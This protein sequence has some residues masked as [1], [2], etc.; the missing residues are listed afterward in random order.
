MS[1]AQFEL[2]YSGDDMN[3]VL[4]RRVYEKANQAL[5]SANQKEERV[6]LLEAWRDFETQ[7]GDETS[8]A[9]LMEKM[10]KRVKKR[11]RVQGQ[12]GV[13]HIICGSFYPSFKN[14][15][16][17]AIFFRPTKVGKSS[18]TIFSPRTKPLN[19]ILNS[20][21]VP[22]HGKRKWKNKN[23]VEKEMKKSRERNEFQER[24]KYVTKFIYMKLNSE[25]ESKY[26]GVINRKKTDICR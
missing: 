15:N 21:Q 14:I 2:K 8:L 22:R 17:Y 12:D 18:S 6:L 7:H 20:W 11:Q 9:K 4:A 5:R 1:Y 25:Y 10:P 24:Y 23:K 19:Q 16:I 3:I 13:K 26:L